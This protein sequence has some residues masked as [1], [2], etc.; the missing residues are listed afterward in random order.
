MR[1]N[2]IIS[3]W[4]QRFGHCFPIHSP[5]EYGAEV[6]WLSAMPEEEE[7]LYP[8]LTYL[9]PVSEQSISDIRGKV[10]MVKPSFSS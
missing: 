4:R 3:M 8:P 10:V 2:S 5:I 6:V 9:S 7:V 1:A